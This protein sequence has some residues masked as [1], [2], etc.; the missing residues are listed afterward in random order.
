VKGKKRRKRLSLF[1]LRAVLAAKGMTQYRLSKETGLT[2]KAIN[3][4]NSGKR[5]PSW[6]NVLAI[7]KVL[8]VDLNAF[9]PDQYEARDPR[10]PA[11]GEKAA[12]S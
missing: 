8:Q 2:Y 1:P 5:L 9:E 10:T 7:A 4:L 6:P 3:D 12:A 11:N